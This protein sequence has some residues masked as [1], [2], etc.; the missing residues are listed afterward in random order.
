[1][2]FLTPEILT[3]DE[4]TINEYVAS[5]EPLKLYEQSLK[6]LNMGRPHILSAA[7]E[8]LLAQMSEVTGVSSDT[9]GKLNN[10]DLEF[11]KIKNEDGEEVRV[12]HGSYISF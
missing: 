4:E 10:A 3:L 1:M 9:F 5:Y 2:V 12:T 7:E 11:P 6:E 8:Q